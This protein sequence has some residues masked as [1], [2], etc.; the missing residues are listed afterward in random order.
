MTAQ[1]ITDTETIRA[2]VDGFEGWY[3]QIEFAPGIVTPGQHPSKRMLQN[4]DEMGLPGD[5]TGLR[6]LD[7][8]CRD[9]FFTFEMERR[10]ADIL[11]IDYAVPEATGFPIG[12][13]IFG[14]HAPY[15]IENVYHLNPEEHGHFDVVLF[16]GVIYHLRNPL[17]ALDA[18]R[19]VTKPGGLIFVTSQLATTQEL[20]E[21]TEPVWQFC[22]RDWLCGDASNKWAPN[23][24]GLKKA[25]EECQ[26]EVLACTDVEQRILL[27][28][29][30]I[31]DASLE[32][33]RKLDAS[34]GKWGTADV[35]DL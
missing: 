25:V 9:G 24:P 33:H 27:K 31:S 15:R 1:R 26:F 11:G 8:G 28:A 2:L 23:V 7:V 34:E 6:V 29:R 16:L 13:K 35:L 12:A 5:C 30:A 3:H 19:S 20:Q 18:V 32:F 4:L 14:S 22:P 21:L 17:L 10:G